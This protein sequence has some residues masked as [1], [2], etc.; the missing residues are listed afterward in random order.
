MLTRAKE[1]AAK[2][3]RPDGA[4]GIELTPLERK[5]DDDGGVIYSTVEVEI[6]RDKRLATL[7][8]HG[9][10]AGA[11][12]P[13]STRCMPKAR[14]AGC[15]AP[16]ASWTMRSC[17]CGTTNMRSA[18]WSSAR[19]AILRTVAAHEQLLLDNR[20]HWLANEIL[21]L[22]EARAEA[23][24]SDVALAGRAGRAGVLLSP[25]CSRK[26]C[27]RSTAP[28]W[29]QGEFE[30]DNRPAATVTLTEGNFGPYPMSNDLTRLQTRFLGEPETGR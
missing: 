28:T 13:R 1:F 16:P 6:D 18:C 3:T 11:P 23:H 30:G 20:E 14:R 8:I 29:P 5:F 4:K 15:C 25:E 2:S 12:R 17:I 27:S 7:T 19:K 21:L 10:D 9:P 22:L 24:R 26:S